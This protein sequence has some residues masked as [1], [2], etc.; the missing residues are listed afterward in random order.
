MSRKTYGADVNEALA[1][2][3]QRD[4]TLDIRLLGIHQVCELAHSATV[5]DPNVSTERVVAVDNNSN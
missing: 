1:V 2:I 3:I 5:V 4:P